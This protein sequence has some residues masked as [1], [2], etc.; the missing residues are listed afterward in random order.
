MAGPSSKRDHSAGQLPTKEIFMRTD[1]EICR[2]VESELQ[3]DPSI[4]D[5][6]I[7]V[8]VRNGVVTLTGDV[9]HYSGRWVAADLVKRV[10]GVRAVANDIQIKIPASGERTDTEIAEAAA[11]ALRWNVSLSGAGITPVVKDGWVSLGGQVSWGYQ[12]IAAETAVRNLMGVKGVSNEISVKSTVKVT[13]VKQ[14]IEEA[15]KRHAILEAKDIEVV[16]HSSIVT[17]K[18][19][20]HSWQEREDATLAAWGAPGVNAVENR[21]TIQ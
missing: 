6:R 11:N 5:T 8:A 7:G 20:V 19:H 4:D 15:F 21:L 16:V 18:G 3:W 17:L 14:K 13:D 1:A 12:K 2:D 9:P 10:K